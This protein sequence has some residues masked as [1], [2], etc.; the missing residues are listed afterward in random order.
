MKK[1]ILGIT[2]P[3]ILAVTLFTCQKQEEQKEKQSAKILDESA[4]AVSVSPVQEGDVSLP[5][6]STGLITTENE[7]RLIF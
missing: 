6:I 1:V 5:V 7:A 4:V 2:L 3:L